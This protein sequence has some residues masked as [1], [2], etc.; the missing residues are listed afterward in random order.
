MNQ[1]VKY[2]TTLGPV[3]LTADTVKKYLVRGN[4]AI[5]DQ[6]ILF[7]LKLCEAQKLNPFVNGEV[8]LIK[9]GTSPAQTVV[10]YGKYV[11]RA[12]E[13][14]EYMYKESGIVVRRENEIIKKDG[15]CLYPG[16][17]LLGGWCRVHKR[18]FDRDVTTYKE[19]AFSE[20]NKGAKTLWSEK[21]ALMIEKVATSQ[22]LREAFPNDFE[23]LY[24]IEEIAPKEFNEEDLNKTP[25]YDQN[26]EEVVAVVN[27]D[28]EITQEERVKLFEVATKVYGDPAEGSQVVKDMLE[29]KGITTTKNLK[30][31]IYREVL[32]DLYKVQIDEE[33]KNMEAETQVPDKS[34]G[35]VV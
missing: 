16:E 2:E 3:E 11:R 22:A 27:E 24:T 25:E 18:K 32:K 19:C 30:F 12:E 17:E 6:E 15:A 20:Y 21:P 7:F 35:E 4:G 13:H 1:V 23:G 26:R 29:K 34:T 10:G 28:R 31:S 5:N 33:I 8:Y 14:P 9:Y